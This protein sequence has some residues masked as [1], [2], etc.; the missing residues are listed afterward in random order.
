MANTKAYHKEYSKRNSE[1]L[2]AT[3]KAYYEEHKPEILAKRKARYQAN[4]EQIKKNYVSNTEV[5]DAKL[6][7]NLSKLVQVLYYTSQNDG[8]KHLLAKDLVAE[9]SNE[10]VDLVE[11]K[12]W[13][14]PIV[15]NRKALSKAVD[16]SEPSVS[17]WLKILEERN[18]VKYVGKYTISGCTYPSNVYMINRNGIDEAFKDAMFDY[19]ILGKKYY[20]LLP[21]KEKEGDVEKRAAIIRNN[22][23]AKENFWKIVK[24]EVDYHNSMIPEKFWTKFLNQDD[25]GDFRDGRCYNIV[26]GTRNPEK[27]PESTDRAEVLTEFFG[28]D[29]FEEFD[30]NSNIARI[31]YYLINN[32]PF[33]KDKDVYYELY[34]LMVDK[35]MSQIKF[36]ST[37]AREIIKSEYMSIYMDLR[38]V[39]MK[40]KNVDKLKD[41][42]RVKQRTLE[43]N[44]S[45]L[46]SMTYNEFLTSLKKA[47]C[48]FLS[49]EKDDGEK[50][51]VL[52]Q[53]MYFKYEVCITNK[54]N[55]I[56][57]KKGLKSINVY[58]GFYFIKG[59]MNKDLFYEVFHQAIEETIALQKQCGIDIISKYGKKED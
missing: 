19:D 27:H 25:N 28:T 15:T 20:E 35:P 5:R 17:N 50:L 57:H 29:Q 54:M 58:D 36:R 49:I 59:K 47:I 23:C 4:K 12:R 31:N 3:S 6:E 55:L 48:K 8:G 41:L 7:E 10:L 34:K 43:E 53:A 45:T 39:Y 56:F 13:F 21:K 46:F 24:Q 11:K 32:K 1:K 2:K 38:S 30:V 14:E 22:E 18:L 33:P 26:C 37:R 52:L 9:Y 40:V 16:C 44:L 51:R 42:N